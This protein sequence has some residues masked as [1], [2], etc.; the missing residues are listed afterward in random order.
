[1]GKRL[2]YVRCRLPPP[3]VPLA[4][5]RHG[6]NEDAFTLTLSEQ[7]R[8]ATHGHRYYTPQEAKQI[9]SNDA[10]DQAFLCST[11]HCMQQRKLVNFRFFERSDLAL[12][13]RPAVLDGLTGQLRGGEKKLSQNRTNARRVA[14][15]V[16]TLLGSAAPNYALS[17]QLCRSLGFENGKRRQSRRNEAELW[18]RTVGMVTSHHTVG[19]LCMP[20]RVLTPFPASCLQFAGPRA[21]HRLNYTARNNI[22][23]RADVE[24]LRKSVSPG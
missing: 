4:A 3:P 15:K 5:G 6:V 22:L 11:S 17:Q 9:L 10:F 8:A 19:F 18:C 14:H 1:M 21:R 12:R 7:F 2:G 16:S 13:Q 23:W 24:R 20:R